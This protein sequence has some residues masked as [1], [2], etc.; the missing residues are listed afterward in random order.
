MLCDVC[1]RNEAVICY[2]E[3]VNGVKKEQHLCRQCAARYTDA[4]SQHLSSSTGNFLASLLAS[5]L[6]AEEEG[7]KD[8]DMQKTNVICPTCKMTYNEFLKYGKFGCEDCYKT[9]GLILDPYLKKIQGNIQHMG[10][11]PKYQDVF[12]EIPEFS[13]GHLKQN[14]EKQIR[15]EK[16][17]DRHTKTEIE[18]LQLKLKQAIAEEEYEEAAKLRDIIK[19]LKVKNDSPDEEVRD[20]AMRD[21]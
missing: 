13:D 14:A 12:V 20:G 3:I 9:F 5:V 4:A 15:T 6:G 2:T 7:M 1:H 8:E 10:K 16:T 11:Q 19:A 17:A 18:R 21:E